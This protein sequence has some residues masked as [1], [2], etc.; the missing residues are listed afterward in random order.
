MLARCPR[1]KKTGSVFDSLTFL[2]LPFFQGHL[3][4][5]LK[6]A[7]NYLRNRNLNRMSDL[8]PSFGVAF[9]LAMSLSPG[10]EESGGARRPS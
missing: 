6:I 8:P 9:F 7:C 10:G 5:C 3:V 2:L 1:T 4:Y